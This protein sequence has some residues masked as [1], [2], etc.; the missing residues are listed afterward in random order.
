MNDGEQRVSCPDLEQSSKLAAWLHEKEQRTIDSAR[1]CAWKVSCAILNLSLLFIWPQC[2]GQDNREIF[3]EISPKLGSL[4]R[5]YPRP[6]SLSQ[7]RPSCSSPLQ[8]LPGI[9]P[10][11]GRWLGVPHHVEVASQ[12]GVLKDEIRQTGVSQTYLR[13]S[14]RL[15]RGHTASVRHSGKW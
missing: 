13:A 5:P 3:R 10:G 15:T 9:R 11:S 1:N 14:S 7:H 2:G 8:Q 4:N 6:V 12:L